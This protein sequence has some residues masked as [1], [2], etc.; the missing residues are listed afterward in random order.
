MCTKHITLLVTLVEN[1]LWIFRRNAFVGIKSGE[2]F[3]SGILNR[4]SENLEESSTDVY[5]LG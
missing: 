5:V 3:P 4:F 1:E 2:Y